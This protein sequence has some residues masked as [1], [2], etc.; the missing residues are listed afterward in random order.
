ML[1]KYEGFLTR[2]RTISRAE[3][4]LHFGKDEWAV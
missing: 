3:D 2:V 4:R 1:Q